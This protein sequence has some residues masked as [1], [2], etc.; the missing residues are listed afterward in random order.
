M[1]YSFGAEVCGI[2]NIERF[3]STQKGFH[4]LDIY[5]EAK[6]VIVFGKQ[7]SASLFEANTNVS[8]TFAKNKLVELLDDI[9]IQLTSNIESQG[10]KAIPIPS[11][12]PYD[13]WDSENKEGKGILSLK[14]SA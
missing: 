6:F 12:E 2:A 7:F 5:S 1:A 8:Y 4:P 3:E 10:Y 9:S 14:L 11:D 13:Y